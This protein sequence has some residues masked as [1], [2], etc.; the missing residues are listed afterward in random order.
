ML[1][2]QDASARR[3]YAGD[4]SK[5][6][7]YSCPACNESVCLKSG[8]K[9]IHHFSHL[10]GSTCD[11]SGE[12]P[13]HL[14]MKLAVWRLLKAD[15]SVS[16]CELE[17][18]IGMR[19]ADVWIK[20][21]EGL[22]VAIECQI[23]AYEGVDIR[24]KLAD[25]ASQGVLAFYLVHTKSIPGCVQSLGMGS[26]HDQEVSIPEWVQEVALRDPTHDFL[27][28]FDPDTGEIAPQ[29]TFVHFW[30]RGRIWLSRLHPV[31]RERWNYGGTREQ[32]DVVLK[33]KRR[34]EAV[35]EFDLREGL[36]AFM[37]PRQTH[38]SRFATGSKCIDVLIAAKSNSVVPRLLQADFEQYKAVA[39]ARAFHKSVIK[40]RKQRERQFFARPLDSTARGVCPVD[41]GGPSETKQDLQVDFGFQDGASCSPSRRGQA[42]KTSSSIC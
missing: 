39:A 3:C 27:W 36:V 33:R 30:D 31:W 17:W 14:S 5:S 32:D 20:T 19:R 41:S 13:E 23:S 21:S 38:A 42:G 34:L 22:S 7:K 37:E 35:A 24:D 4:A 12:S 8:T 9:R 28:A 2:A 16:M 6:D 1:V 29:H 15:P 25:Y 26:L 40:R 18:R 11:N 10:A